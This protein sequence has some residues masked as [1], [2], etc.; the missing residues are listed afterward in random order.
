MTI[1]QLSLN[2]NAILP[3]GFFMTDKQRNKSFRADPFDTIIVG[4]GL[5]G[6]VQALLLANAGG[7]I[8]IVDRQNP[9]TIQSAKF[10]GRTT[11]ISHGS[12]L[13]LKSAGIWADL[14][15]KSC[16][17]NTIY[18]S[19]GGGPWRMDFDY[20]MVGNAP[21]GHIVLNCDLRRALHRAMASHKNISLFA[22]AEILSVQTDSFRAT[23]DLRAAPKDKTQTI[24]AP[25][26]IAADG[27]RSSLRDMFDIPCRRHDYGQ[28]AVIATVAHELPHQNAAF[29]CFLSDGPLA[30]LPMSA[31]GGKHCSSLVWSEESERTKILMRLP[32][33][34][35][36]DLLQQ[37]FGGGLGGFALL[38]PRQAYPLDLVAASRYYAPRMALI[39]DAAHGIHPIAGQGLNLGLRDAESLSQLWRRQKKLGLDFGSAQMLADYDR[40]RRSDVFGMI[41]ATHGLNWL[42]GRTHPF[43]RGLRGVGLKMVDYCPPLK[44]AFIRKAM[45]L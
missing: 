34:E 11:A 25:L 32:D 35:F 43:M 21:M 17:I 26:L 20:R 2:I 16:P 13:I 33:G 19:D 3:S 7:T 24:T 22:P 45:G 42:F 4:G 18:I 15:R 37:K 1:A 14:S 44:Q 41:A 28:T 36:C 30:I 10:D 12:H 5:V 40:G 9:K 29:E 23:I 27:R 8:A 31:I 38:S 39:G 6:A